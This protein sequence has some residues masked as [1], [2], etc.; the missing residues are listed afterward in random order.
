MLKRDEK[1][2]WHLT[3][4]SINQAKRKLIGIGAILDISQFQG[5][6]KPLDEFIKNPKGCRSS[7]PRKIKKY[8]FSPDRADVIDHALHILNLLQNNYKFKQSH[9]L[10]G[11]FQ[12]Q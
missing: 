5:Q 7:I 2:E 1:E 6:K 10:N 11:G 8:K 4:A 12:I 9:Q 3:N